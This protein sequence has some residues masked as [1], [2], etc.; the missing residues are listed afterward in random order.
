MPDQMQ[1]STS[2][3]RYRRPVSLQSALINVIVQLSKGIYS[4]PLSTMVEHYYNARTGPVAAS[5]FS[6][7]LG[8]DVTTAFLSKD[9]QPG[10]PTLYWMSPPSPLIP[11]TK[12][13][14]S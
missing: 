12:Y 13:F 4:T 10:H 5:T 8:P 6:S 1:R 11:S 7:L 3:L 14:L 9:C 2:W